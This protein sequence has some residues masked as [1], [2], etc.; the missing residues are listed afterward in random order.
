MISYLCFPSFYSMPIL[1][2]LILWNMV[3]NKFIFRAARKFYQCWM[4]NKYH[5]RA[6]D[7]ITLPSP[8]DNYIKCILPFQKLNEKLSVFRENLYHMKL[9]SSVLG[10]VWF[11]NCI[12]HLHSMGKVMGAKHVYSSAIIIR[13]KI[14][15]HQ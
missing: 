7:R 15:C 6:E 11:R 4:M 8:K 5:N 2:S 14:N 12:H 13:A 3:I 1:Y 10:N 9:S